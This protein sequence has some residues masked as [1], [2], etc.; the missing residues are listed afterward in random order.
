MTSKGL[1]EL[2]Y[3]IDYEYSP[4]QK[5]FKETNGYKFSDYKFKNIALN[6]YRSIKEKKKSNN[7][8]KTQTLIL[9]TFNGFK[10][11]KARKILIEI[12]RE[13]KS[14]IDKR[15]EDKRE[16]KSNMIQN[17]EEIGR[18]ILENVSIPYHKQNH[19]T[20]TQGDIDSWENL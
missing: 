13:L 19:E 4:T 16:K 7:D 20:I 1:E 12:S 17:H 5:Q 15:N 8:L 11:D 2:I 9:N 14:K 6:M 3:I 18:F 10:M